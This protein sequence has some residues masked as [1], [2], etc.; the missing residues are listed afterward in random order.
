MKEEESSI[1]EKKFILKTQTKLK[2]IFTQQQQQQKIMTSSV[3]I[4]CHPNNYF[5]LFIAFKYRKTNK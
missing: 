1:T 3:Q 4:N 5:F 2:H